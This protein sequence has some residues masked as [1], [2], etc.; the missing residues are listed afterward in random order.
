L[1]TSWAS[2]L[3]WPLGGPDGEEATGDAIAAQDPVA[4]LTFGRPEGMIK[5]VTRL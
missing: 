4:G 5:S 2:I 1:V 3:E